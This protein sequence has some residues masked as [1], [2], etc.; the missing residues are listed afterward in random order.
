LTDRELDEDFARR[1]RAQ[2]GTALEY[3][4]LRIAEAL[5]RIATALEAR[6]PAP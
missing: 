3:G 1:L 4:L 6:P 2:N 5:E